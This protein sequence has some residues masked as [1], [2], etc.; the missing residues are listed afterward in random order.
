MN[1]SNGIVFLTNAQ[2]SVAGGGNGI[3]FAGTSGDVATLG[4]TAGAW[5]FV[6]G[7]NATL[8]LTSAQTTLTGGGDTIDVNAGS[9]TIASLYGT[10]GSA[11]TVNGASATL[12]LNAVQANVNSSGNTLNLTGNNTVTLS[13]TA[14]AFV[15]QPAIGV[16]TVGG[17]GSTDSM[18]FSC[19]R[20]RQ[21]VRAARPYDAVRREYR[22][23]ARRH[24]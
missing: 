17:F 20:L 23:R 22:H 5:D 1:G 24:R 18:T 19:V 11:D 10:G 3:I 4:G 2:A 12:D 6:A 9:G 14:E 15:F 7:S 8:N 13:G 21:L 16:N